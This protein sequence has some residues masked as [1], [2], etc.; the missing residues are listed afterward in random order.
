MVSA[1]AVGSS[2]TLW[3]TE[4][5]GFLAV[6]SSRMEPEKKFRFSDNSKPVH[7]T[8]KITYPN[9]CHK[10]VHIIYMIVRINL[11]GLTI[12]I[13]RATSGAHIWKSSWIWRDWGRHTAG[14]SIFS[15]KSFGVFEPKLEERFEIARESWRRRRR[16]RRL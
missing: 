12:G 8:R 3:E 11:N 14:Q 9:M 13:G 16:C 7:L 4:I 5:F 6:E 15:Q 2:V 1:C 10:R